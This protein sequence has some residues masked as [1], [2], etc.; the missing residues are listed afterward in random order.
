MPSPSQQRVL[1]DR[2]TK[3]LT[4]RLKPGDIAVIHHADLD[5]TA[6]HALIECRVSAVVNAAPSISGRYPNRG[7]ALL[8]DADIPLIDEAGDAAFDRIADS[9][10]GVIEGD[11]LRMADGACIAGKLMTPERLAEAMAAAR[12]NLNTEL[13]HFARNTLAYLD[14]EKGLLFDPVDA[15]RLRTGLSDRHVL[16]VVRGEGYKA[17]LAMLS[18]YL[19]DARPVLLAVDGGA[20]ALLE[21]K[22]RP[23]IILG[24]MDSVSDSALQCGAELIVHGYP[25]GDGRGAPGL[26]RIERLGLQAA[27]FRAQGTSEDVAM[28]LADELGARLI[29]AVGTHFSLE[30]FLDKGRAGMASTFLTRLRIGSKLVDAKGVARLSERQRPR[31]SE[32]LLLVFAFT[33]PIIAVTVLSPMGQVL[34]RWLGVWLQHMVHG[35]H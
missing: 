25:P 20:D 12:E 19:L 5:T 35:R 14:N 33:T 30:E 1:K 11:S 22:L 32:L 2:R 9:T 4:R 31:W 10:A 8:L 26:A 17:D 34:I 24:D 15:P 3:N 23:D 13:D 7:P 21:A 18:D 6:A 27:V 16:I 29:V 28:L